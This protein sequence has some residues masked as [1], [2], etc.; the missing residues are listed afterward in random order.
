MKEIADDLHVEVSFRLAFQESHLKIILIS[1]QHQPQR[2]ARHVIGH[3]HCVH[4]LGRFCWWDF[5]SVNPQLSSYLGFGPTIFSYRFLCYRS[6]SRRLLQHTSSLGTHLELEP[7]R[8]LSS[9]SL[10]HS[11]CFSRSCSPLRLHFNLNLSF[12]L[13]SSIPDQP[14][15]FASLNPDLSARSPPRAGS[16]VYFASGMCNH[17]PM[18]RFTGALCESCSPESFGPTCESRPAGCSSCEDGYL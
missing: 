14:P 13:S 8:R 7:S 16:G 9:A 10:S 3:H 4:R 17:A 11:P 2:E 12:S 6:T 15:C 1:F 18:A 5:C